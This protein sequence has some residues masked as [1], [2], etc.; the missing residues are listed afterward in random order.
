[1]IVRNPYGSLPHLD[2]V[3]TLWS[4]QSKLAGV[5]TDTVQALVTIKRAAITI[6][7]QRR[8]RHYFRCQNSIRSVAQPNP[9][10]VCYH[11]NLCPLARCLRLSRKSLVDKLEETTCVVVI[12]VL[13][14]CIC[15][16]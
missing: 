6:W 12:E 3:L 14:A 2:S 13:T 11:L 9:G 4:A 8:R 1:M 5:E 16:I 15:T 10:R 7:V